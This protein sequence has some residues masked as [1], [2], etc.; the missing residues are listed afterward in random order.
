M[1]VQELGALELGGAFVGKVLQEVLDGVEGAHRAAWEA[2]RT[3]LAQAALFA[4]MASAWDWARVLGVG[5]GLW[6]VLPLALFFVRR[7]VKQD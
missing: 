5:V 7:H 2:W 1:S 3:L 4:A 6:V